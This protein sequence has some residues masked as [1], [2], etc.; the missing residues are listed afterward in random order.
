[1]TIETNQDETSGFVVSN[2]DMPQVEAAP[3]VDE[4]KPEEQASSEEAAPSSEETPKAEPEAE[5]QK[6]LSQEDKAERG[7]GRVQKRFN[8]LTR[9]KAEQTQRAEKAEAKLAELEAKNA[10][11]STKEP[12]E[13]DFEDFEKYL[14][15][16]EEFEASKQEDPKA[17]PEDTKQVDDSKEDKPPPLSD[18]QK[19]AM[20]V[21]R[22]SVES[23]EKPEDFEAVALNPE[24]PITGD[25]L[26]ALAECDDPAKVMYHLGQ[27]KD[28][29][30]DIANKTPAQ[31][32]REIAKL[33]LNVVVKPVK[34]IKTTNAPDPISPVRG[35]DAQEKPLSE[36]SFS[37]YEAHQNKLERTNK[38]W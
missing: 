25:M 15:A 24:V 19:V 13:S 22:E 27:N 1:M 6:E 2:D 5:E 8:D 9:Q 34:P 29:A 30:A 18:S 21:I 36:M 35:S 37:E 14:D 11:P 16:L 38:S 4:Q 17:E 3:Q 7:K 26:E 33:D 12:V 10:T 32:A 20:E 28:L 23:S 31:Q